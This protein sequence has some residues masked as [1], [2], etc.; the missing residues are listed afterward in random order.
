MK[1]LRRFVH[2]FKFDCLSN[3]FLGLLLQEWEEKLNQSTEMAESWKERYERLK[4]THRA[5]R[6][7]DQ[8]RSFSSRKSDNVGN[9]DQTHEP[10][11]LFGSVK[12]FSTPGKATSVA[13][14]SSGLAQQA[15]T[16]VSQMNNNFNCNQMNHNER[17]GS[18]VSSEMESETNGSRPF[19]RSSQQ[20]PPREFSSSP[21]RSADI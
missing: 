19:S 9:E 18:V 3:L 20:R 16:L 7:M 1:I 4:E 2:H 21:Q 5:D 13:S 14:F 11:S 8:A 12:S 10:P 15:K 6:Y 17:T